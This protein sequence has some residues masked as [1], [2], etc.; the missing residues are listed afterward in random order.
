MRT[1]LLRYQITLL[2]KGTVKDSY[3]AVKAEYTPYK[4]VK[5]ALISQSGNKVTDNNEVFNIKSKDFQI[6]YNS[7]VSESMRIDF[8][9]EIYKILSI[10]EVGFR[11]SLIIKSELLN[12]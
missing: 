5:A 7:L 4:T 9:G 1:G 2:Q 10:S 6:R 12:G 8:N 3:G 11:D